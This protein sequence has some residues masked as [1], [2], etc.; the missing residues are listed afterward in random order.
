MDPPVMEHFTKAIN[1]ILKAEDKGDANGNSY[2]IHVKIGDENGADFVSPNKIETMDI[3]IFANGKTIYFTTDKS[4]KSSAHLVHGNN[5]QSSKQNINSDYMYVPELLSNYQQQSLQSQQAYIN[6]Y[7]QGLMVSNLNNNNYGLQ[8]SNGNQFTLAA[9]LPII[10]IITL[11]FCICCFIIIG[12]SGTSCYFYGR[13][14][15]KNN[16]K[17]NYVKL[18]KEYRSDIEEVHIVYGSPLLITTKL[19]K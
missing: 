3:P 4:K 11:L 12:L 10:A 13:N 7:N 9:L 15:G 6:G 14:S 2:P 16:N 17:S 1:K 19:N 8:Q 5:Y 18:R